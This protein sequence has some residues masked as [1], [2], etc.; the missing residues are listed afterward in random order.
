MQ[1]ASRFLLTHHHGPLLCKS[2]LILRYVVPNKL[3]D[4]APFKTVS[5][6][7][8]LELSVNQLHLKTMILCIK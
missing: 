3:K 4:L 8:D 1:T 2:H 6:I 7:N 5:D